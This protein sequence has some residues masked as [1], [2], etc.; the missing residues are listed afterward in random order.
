[1]VFDFDSVV[2]EFLSLFL[3]FSLKFLL[4]FCVS[5]VFRVFSQASSSAG[6]LVGSPAPLLHQR[7][8]QHSTA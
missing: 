8:R 1:M 7:F 2:S 6:I 4:N 5:P 3:F